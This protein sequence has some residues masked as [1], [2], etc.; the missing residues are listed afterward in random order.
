ME[1]NFYGAV[2]LTKAL[3][4]YMI[5]NGGGHIAVTS[6]ISG[7]FGFPLRAA[8]SAS[9]HALHGFFETLRAELKNKNIKVTILCPGRVKTNISVNALTKNGTSYGKMS[10]GQDNG[11][12]PEKCAKKYLSAIKRNKKDVNIGSVEIFMVYLKRLF[13]GIF[14]KIVSKINPE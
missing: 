3:V 5:N 2:Y 11:I 4:P 8:Y 1:I 7:K 10:K 12:S 9:K 13:P 14:Y 6:S